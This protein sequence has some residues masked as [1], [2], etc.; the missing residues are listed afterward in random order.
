MDSFPSPTCSKCGWSAAEADGFS[1]RNFLRHAGSLWQRNCDLWS[2]RM[3]RDCTTPKRVVLKRLAKCFTTS[4]GTRKWDMRRS[5]TFFC[6]LGKLRKWNSSTSDQTFGWLRRATPHT[7]RVRSFF[8]LRCQ[9]GACFV[10]PK[11]RICIL[12]WC[13]DRILGDF[14]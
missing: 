3:C 9:V 4:L 8:S 7:V 5:F 12:L 14:C 1:R 11:R 10:V 13:V 2:E 6:N